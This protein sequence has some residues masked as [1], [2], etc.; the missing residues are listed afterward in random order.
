MGKFHNFFKFR[1][2]QLFP[3]VDVEQTGKLLKAIRFRGLHVYRDCIPVTQFA[4][5]DPVRRLILRTSETGVKKKRERE[6]REEKRRKKEEKEEE[7]RKKKNRR[8]AFTLI[9]F[10]YVIK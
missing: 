5:S 3:N 4:S 2:G 10:S 8:R 6:R 1:V 9:S 7:E